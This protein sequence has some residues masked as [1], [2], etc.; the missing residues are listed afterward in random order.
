MAKIL[1]IEPDWVL[2]KIYQQA[3]EQAGHVVVTA[4]SAQQAIDVADKNSPELVIVEL[5]LGVH[6]GI[7]F[8]YEFRTYSEWLYT[9]VIIN[10]LVPPTEFQ[11]NYVLD[12]ELRIYT[13][14]YKPQA[15]LQ[16]LLR[17]VQ[18]CLELSSTSTSLM[19]I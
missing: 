7:E 17:S 18:E 13:Y 19:A 4:N 2:S 15:T 11:D 12:H 8:M 5:Q 14:L 10:S 9:P 1:L 16:Q 3:L 6:N